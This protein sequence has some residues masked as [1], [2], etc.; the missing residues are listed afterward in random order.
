MIHLFYD[1]TWK[2]LKHRLV[3]F[4]DLNVRF[5]FSVSEACLVKD[6]LVADIRASF[7]NAYVLTTSNIGKDIGGKFA[8]I[9]LYLSLGFRS[10]F[11]IFLHDKQS[12]HSLEGDT[13]KKNL[14][15][16]IDYRNYKRILATFA[17]D[18]KIGIVGAGEHLV[19]EY[20]P[21]NGTFINN[22]DRTHFFLKKYGIS[23]SNYEFIGG[24]MYWMKAP[25]IE[26]FFTKYN[27]MHIRS[28]LEAGNVMDNYGSTN[29][30]TWE[31][32]LSWAATNQGFRVCGI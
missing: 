2:E 9:D 13:W 6:E 22:N 31:R 15:K 20:N 7:K 12:P 26:K 5:L 11:I 1:N 23:I 27:P 17:Q 25:I 16:I 4:K 3:Y 10:D 14:M 29:A 18:E 30:H 19:N 24:T 32:V 21:A 28:E 8:L